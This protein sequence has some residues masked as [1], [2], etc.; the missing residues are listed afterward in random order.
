VLQVP[1]PSQVDSGV[2]TLVA[3]GQEADMQG[4]PGTH[5]WHW[6]ASHL[7]FVPHVEAS[8]VAQLPSGSGAPVATFEQTPSWAAMHDLQAV[9]QAVSQQTPWAQKV[10]RHS[11]PSEQAAPF[12]L[13]P[14]ELL[15]QLNGVTH[16]LLLV[17]AMKQRGPLQM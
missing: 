4:V 6:P 3:V 2:K 8:D 14:H 11:D 17:Q 10:L 12:S 9:L 7:P 5:F 1:A 13:R 15:A 16:W